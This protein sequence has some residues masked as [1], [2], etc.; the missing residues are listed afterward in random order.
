MIR[1]E[2]LARAALLTGVAAFALTATPALAQSVEQTNPDAAVEPPAAAAT[3][4]A[5]AQTATEAAAASDPEIIV[6]A[7]RRNEILLD[8]PIAVTAYSGEQL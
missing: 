2:L 6:T 4:S 8:V 5:D 3:P 1:S 7:R